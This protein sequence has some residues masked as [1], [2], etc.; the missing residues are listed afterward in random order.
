MLRLREG[1]W[2]L[3]PNVRPGERSRALY[4]TSLFTLIS[5]AQTLGIAGTET[6]LLSELGAARLPESFIAASIVAVLGS[7][8][9]AARV[10][11]SRNDELFSQML[12]GSAALLLLATPG[13]GAGIP[14]VVVG[15]FCFFYLTQAVFLN[16]FWTFSGDYFDTLTS[17]RLFPVFTVGASLGGLVGGGTTVLVAQFAG[18]VNLVTGWAV[19]LGAAALLLRVGRRPL[20]RWGP[21]E[22]EEAD[23]TSVAGM[24]GAAAYVRGSRLG[25]WLVISALGMVLALFL[26]QYL[27]SDIF[28]RAFPDPGELAAFFGV[29]LAI[30]NLVE[31]GLELWVTPW[32][33][34]R[35]GVPTSHLVHPVLT[36]L[37]FGALAYHRSVATAIGARVSRELVENAVA[38]PIRTLVYNA[39]PARFR[40]RI[41]AFLEGIVVYAGMSTAGVLLLLV[42]DPDPLWLCAAGGFA[43]LAYLVANL[44]ARQ[45]YLRTLVR[46]IRAGRLDLA[47]LEEEIGSWEATRLAELFD[48]MLADERD[49]PSRSF[50]QLVPALT[51]RGLTEPLLRGARAGND[52]IRRRCVEALVGLD[53]DAAIPG[54]LEALADPDPGVRLVALLGLGE[55]TAL[56]TG[57][58][59]RASELLVDPDP[60]VRAAAARACGE[61]G[62]SALRSMLQ[63]ESGEGAVAALRVAPPALRAL[64]AARTRDPDPR[65]RA[66]ALERFAEIGG[67]GIEIDQIVGALRDPHPDVR[68]A[69]VRVLAGL[70][71]P[72]AAPAIAEALADGAPEVQHLAVDFLA[73]LG[74]RGV[75]AASP[76]LR[77]DRERAIEGAL[78]VVAEA[79]PERHEILSR[80]LRHHAQRIW[81]AV[82]ALQRLPSESSVAER[83]LRVAYADALL[84]SRRLAFRTLALLENE[85]I[86]GNVEKALRFGTQRSRGDALEVL[87]NL[88]D[89]RASQLIV[90]FHEAGPL[91]ERFQS[92]EW[93]VRVPTEW[94]LLLEASRRAETRWV[95]MAAEAVVDGL[96]DNPEQEETMERLLAFKQVPLFANLTLEQLEAVSQ[97]TR[98]ATFLPGEIIMREGDP[99]GELFLLLEGVLDVIVHYGSESEERVNEIK[100]F[101]Y[102]GEMAILDNEPRTATVVARERSRL[103]A[104]DGGSFKELLLQVPEISFEI[105]RVLTARVRKA[106]RRLAES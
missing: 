11:V 5:A 28:A 96:G 29:Y 48:Q 20:R 33:I 43:A 45:E 94:Q 66:A 74:E 106:E 38:N 15:L 89:R 8:V 104:L 81:Y 17:K 84:R 1:L 6:L 51:Q 79:S 26:A 40:G 71:P 63:S 4:F 91:D 62:L 3:L 58:A 35:F 55:R 34:R 97:L 21:L 69:A 64:L 88:G 7:L 102:V 100:P 99:G 44:R 75:E 85:R 18:P 72:G 65:V 82:V 32:L 22:L 83:F 67:E 19:L 61:A 50:L 25:R 37:S 16:H 31:V 13:A 56:P 24:R 42:G 10:G 92:I 12:L 76:Y 68:A 105:F 52:E 41:R 9:Y 30:T 27:Y 49:R 60:R 95:R 70:D 73:S 14:A 86:I 87:S 101:N 90:L 93:A 53:D 54:V 2:A 57:F 80:E 23:E 39:L 36:L 77:D 103:L 98:E 78:R 59:A 47:D 46:G